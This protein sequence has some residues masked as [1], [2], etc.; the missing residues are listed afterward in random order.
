MGGGGGGVITPPSF[1]SGAWRISI[2]GVN[3]ELEMESDAKRRFAGR[4]PKRRL[5]TTGRRVGQRRG[6]LFYFDCPSKRE[7]MAITAG[8]AIRISSSRKVW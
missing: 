1:P 3:W 8:A 4:I 2:S 5:G 7:A 6:G